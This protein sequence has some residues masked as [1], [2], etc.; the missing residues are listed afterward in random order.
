LHYVIQGRTEAADGKRANQREVVRVEVYPLQSAEPDEGKDEVRADVRPLGEVEVEARL[1]ERPRFEV[2]L[3]HQP[4]M[5]TVRAWTDL[6]RSEA[7]EQLRPLLLARVAA[8]ASKEGTSGQVV[9][10]YTLSPAPLVRDTLSGKTT[11]RL[12][13]VLDGHLD[14]FFTAENGREDEDGK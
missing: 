4:T 2:H 14:Q 13:E 3:S 11:G 5:T 7:V 12:D 6:S 8:S 10:R 9:R 1:L